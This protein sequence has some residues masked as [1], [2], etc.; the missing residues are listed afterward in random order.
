[1]RLV[2]RDS[3]S[4]ARSHP[5]IPSFTRVSH[6][7]RSRLPTYASSPSILVHDRFG[8][9]STLPASYGDVGNNHDSLRLVPCRQCWHPPCRAAFRRYRH[10][11]RVSRRVRARCPASA[12]HRPEMGGGVSCFNARIDAYQTRAAHRPR[13]MIPACNRRMVDFHMS[14]C[15]WMKAEAPPFDGAS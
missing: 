10:R 1:M 2:S 13:W 7:T 15:V 5:T 3:I 8:D 14:G 9:D 4:S 11:N 12:R 6:F